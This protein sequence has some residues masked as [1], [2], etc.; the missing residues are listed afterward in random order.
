M[1]GDMMHPCLTPDVIRNQSDV[2]PSCLTVHRN[3]SY[4]SRI[5]PMIFLGIPYASMIFHSV[6]RCILSN[7]FSKSI[8]LIYNDDRHSKL[9]SMM[10]LRQK[11]LSVHDLFLLNPLCSFLKMVST[12]SLILSKR[13]RHRTFPGTDSRVIPLKLLHW[14]KS[15]FFG[16]LTIIPST[17][18]VHSLHPIS[19]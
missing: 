16:S 9:C 19:C 10:F 5:I 13:I 4:I 2:D 17:A 12:L 14:V 7:A 6:I 8:K 3:P 15:P 1:S 18:L 11:M